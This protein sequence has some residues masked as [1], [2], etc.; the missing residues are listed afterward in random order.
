MR[1]NRIITGALLSFVLG[2]LI[3]SAWHDLAGAREISRIMRLKADTGIL[4][5]SRIKNPKTRELASFRR[6][7]DPEFLSTLIRRQRV[8]TRNGIVLAAATLLPI[9][10][11]IVVFRNKGNVEPAPRHVP[12][13]AAADGGL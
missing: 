2:V 13:K 7:R 4:D 5:L 10:G 9:V 11:L 8:L 1:R 12:S 6:R 3:W